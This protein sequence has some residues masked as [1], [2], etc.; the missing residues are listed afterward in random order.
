[1]QFAVNLAVGRPVETAALLSFPSSGKGAFPALVIECTGLLQPSEPR[2][3]STVAP[4]MESSV[5]KMP[6]TT[7]GVFQ[8][9]MSCAGSGLYSKPKRVIPGAAQ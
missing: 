7:L 4:L 8:R 1:M 5:Y 2:R 6:L 9:C 3:R